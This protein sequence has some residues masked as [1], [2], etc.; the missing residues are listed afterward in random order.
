MTITKYNFNYLF[1]NF[2]YD[3][4]TT[5]RFSFVLQVVTKLFYIVTS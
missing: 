1:K 5:L 4:I 2:Y 3:E